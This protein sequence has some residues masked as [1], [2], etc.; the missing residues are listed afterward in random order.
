MA[1][2]TKRALGAS[3][4]KLLTEKPLDKITVTDIAEDCGISRMTFYYH[5]QDIYDLIE[6][7]CAEDAAKALGD[8]KTYDT[9]QEGFLDIFRLVQDNQVFILN[10][11][12]SV[13]REQV[14]IYLYRVAYDLI[15]GVVQE[16]AAGKHVREED[17]EFIANFYKYAFVG[18]M[19]D[20][21]RE[22]MHED[23]KVLVDRFSRIIQGDFSRALDNFE[24]IQHK[25]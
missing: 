7:T 5:F 11:Y 15:I 13:S 2:T 9:W 10:L 12:H 18:T 3:L 8:K 16:K 17:K 1:Q 24:K 19:L 14:E 22:G 23:P 6:W 21:I 25:H 4:K 20:W